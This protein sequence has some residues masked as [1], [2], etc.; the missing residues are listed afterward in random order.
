MN[1]IKEQAAAHIDHI[2]LAVHAA[3]EAPNDFPVIFMGGM[4]HIVV[5]T[6]S[7]K[8]T[9]PSHQLIVLNF[10]VEYV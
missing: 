1:R 4:M 6:I 2:D 5:D 9:G 7:K 10:V 8:Q 3:I